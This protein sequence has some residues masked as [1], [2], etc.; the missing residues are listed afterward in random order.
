MQRTWF[1]KTLI[2]AATML[3]AISVR[4]GQ[5]E[6]RLVVHDK[7][8]TTVDAM[9]RREAIAQPVATSKGM[10][11]KTLGVDVTCWARNVML[12]GKP[13][14]ERYHD[15]KYVDRL[16]VARANLNP[17]DHTIWPGNHVFTIAKDGS[18]TANSPELMVDGNV[19][20]IKCYPFTVRA[21]RANPVE[22]APGAAR[23]AATL[24]ELTIREA[25]NNA[26]AGAKESKEK[27]LELLPEFE[28][29]SPLT[30]WL[31]GNRAE[32][33]YV[34]HPLGLMFHL[35]ADGAKP[36]AD[37]EKVLP[38][39]QQ[40]PFGVEIPLYSFPVQ[41]D[42]GSRLVTADVEQLRWQG[43]AETLE[44]RWF[45]RAKPYE[46]R[47]AEGA[48][49][50]RIDGDPRVRPFKNFRVDRPDQTK[51]TTRLLAVEFERRHFQPGETI[52]ARVQVLDSAKGLLR[53]ETDA[54]ITARLQAYEHAEWTALKA[55]VEA[56]GRLAIAVP[57]MTPGLYLLEV[58]AVPNASDKALAIRRWI[59]IA[60]SDTV[61]VGLFTRRGRTVF[62]RGEAFWLGFGATG[63]KHGLPAKT[64]LE[65]DLVDESGNAFP[66]LRD[67]SSSE[68]KDGETFVAKLD[69]D[70]SLKLAAGAYTA[71]ARIGSNA[72][73]PFAMEIVE[74][75]PET[76]F[77]NMLTGKY[78]PQ[79]EIYSRVLRNGQG[80][81]ALARSIAEMGHN[82]F[83]G[84]SYDLNRVVHGSRELEQVAR[85][86]AELGPWE[87]YYQPSGRDRFMEA[88]VRHNL[89]FYED[90]MTYNDTMLPRDPVILEALSRYAGLETASLR[91]SPAFKGVCLYDEI[92][93]V[94]DTGKP[95][96]AQ[97]LTA[98]EMTYRA[99]NPGLTSVDALRA[100]DRYTSRPFGQRK[101]EDLQK[102][103]TW[104]AHEDAEWGELSRSMASSVKAVM[105]ESKNFTLQR[106]W[107]GNGGNIAANG[108]A[109]DVFE[110]LD[111]AACV[112]YKDGGNGDRPVFA[113]MQ[114]D[115]LR[116]REDLP[117]WTQLHS[118][119]ASGLY[120]QHL[121][122]QAF[123]GLSQK[124]DGF[125]YFS[126][127]ASHLE[128]TYTDNR[129]VMRD[130][131]EKLCTPLGDFFLAAKRGYK[132]VA[133][134]YSR[135]ASYLEDKKPVKPAYACE[136]LWVACMRAGFPADFVFDADVRA[137]KLSEYDVVF[138]PGFYF[139]DE[140]PP[141]ILA[142]LRKVVN[143]G[144]V[145]AAERGS[146]LPI[147][148]LQRL[149]SDFDEYDDKMGGAFPRYIDF[150]S[151]MVWDQS[152][153]TT[154]L[155]RTF[156]G[157]H[158]EPAAEH[159]LLVGPDWLRSGKGEYMVLPNFADTGFSFLHKTM[160]QAPDTPRLRFPK[161]PPVCYDMLEMRRQKVENDGD[162]MTL[163]ADFRSC[164]GKIYAFMP[165]E[166]DRVELRVQP[167]V[168][169]GAPLAYA[170]QVLGKDGTAIDAAFP[171][172]ITLS[173]AKGAVL[174]R[175][176][177]AAAPAF[178]GVYAV[179][180]NSVAGT[181]GIAVR[182]LI[183]GTR[184]EGSVAVQSGKMPRA[185][186]D[187]AA[188]RISDLELLKKFM[189]GTEPVTIALDSNQDW[190][191]VEA[192]HLKKEIET[193]GREVK[194]VP[195]AK[196]VRLPVAWNEL[197]PIVDGT[198]LWR[199]NVVEPG[200][201][202]DGPLILIGKRNDNRLIDA[203]IQRD[204]LAESI[205]EH[206]PGP[207]CALL[208]CV[209]Q[210]FSNRYDT[211]TLLA[212]DTEGLRKGVEVLMTVERQMETHS[213]RSAVVTATPDEKAKLTSAKSTEAAPS[214][215]TGG[216]SNEDRVQTVNVDTASGRI[217][218][219]TFGYGK[220]LF[221][222][223][224]NGALLWKQFLPEHNVYS[225][226]WYDDGKRIVAATGMGNWVF[227]LD[228]KDGR[229][230]CKMLGSEWPN[231]HY[232]EGPANTEGQIVVNAAKRQI[233]V[234]G[235]TGILAIDFDGRKQWYFDRAEAI[236][237]YPELAEQT[238]A[239]Q[240]GN[241]VSVGNI[242]VSPNGE[243]VAYS[244]TRIVGTT[245][246]QNR[247]VD[248]WGHRPMLL[249]TASGKILVENTEDGGSNTSPGGW[250]VEYPAGANGPVFEN[251]QFSRVLQE[252]GKLGPAIA[253][254]TGTRLNDGSHLTC[255]PNAL[256]RIKGG[257][258]LWSVN[259]DGVWLPGFDCMNAA[260]TR[261]YRSSWD[262]R[263]RC[264]EVASGKT[265][266]EKPLNATARLT[267]LDGADA[268]GLLAAGKD[269]AL[270][271][272]DA[273]GKMLWRTRMREHNDI[274][275]RDYAAYVAAGVRRDT[276]VS[277][278]VFSTMVDRPGD[279]ANI[280][281][282]GIEQ[283]EN[284][285]FERDADWKLE[286]A[287]A[288]FVSPGHSAM[289][290]GLEEGRALVLKPGELVTQTLSRRVMPNTTYLLE[291]MY[292][293]EKPEAK[294]TAGAMIA[295]VK[296]AL[297][298]TK[299]DDASGWAFGRV[300][301]KTLDDSKS[302]TVGFEVE[303]G[304][305]WVDK[306]SL[307]PVRFP[308][309]N[310]LANTELQQ[311]EPTFVRDI[312]VQYN[313]I[314][315][316]LRDKL[317]NRNHVASF[318]QGDTNKARAFTQETAFLHNG[319]LD[320]VGAQWTYEP[321]SLGF[322]VTL[323]KP[324]YV[325][326][327]VLYLNN[328]TPE[329]TYRTIAVVANELD[330]GDEVGGKKQ[331]VNGM[332][333]LVSL[334]R[335]NT[336][337]FV[338][339]NFPK[340]IFTDSI[341]ILPGKHPGRKECITEIELYGPLGGETGKRVANAEPLDR[342]ML[343]GTASRVPAA[344]PEDL[345]G[346]YEPV[347]APRVQ[348]PV[349]N[350]GAAMFDGLFAYGDP[351]GE[352][353]SV[354]MLDSDPR[355]RPPPPEKGKRSPPPERIQEGP[356]WTLASVT[357]TTTPAHYAGR[358]F[359]GSADARLH[360]VAD[361]GTYL[362]AYKTGGRVYS[363]PLPNGDDVYFGSDD[364]KLYKI[365]VD[366]GALIWEYGTAGRVRGAPALADGIVCIA[367][368]DGF[369]HAVSADSG[370]QKWK[371]P[372]APLTRAT[373][374]VKGDAVFLGDEKGQLHAFD[375][376]SGAAKWTVKING[377]VSQCPVVTDDG[378]F[379]ASEQGEVAL[380]AYDG[381]LKWKRDLGARCSGQAIATQTQIIVPTEN[382][383]HVL[384]RADGKVDPRF[385]APE[386]IEKVISVGVYRSRVYLQTAEA[387]TDFKNPPRTYANYQGGVRVWAPVLKELKEGGAK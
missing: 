320:D 374:A 272:F 103:K 11:M 259:D 275:A 126:L 342:P 233:L 28:N 354:R 341:K 315:S 97:F 288:N 317:R 15:G 330:S 64:M 18:I 98:E 160:F 13:I 119:H 166:I 212:N 14:F 30:I 232:Y 321:D 52:T 368:G 333:R 264:V 347:Q 364:G 256:T 301:V 372:I 136:G 125:T 135:E 306:A 208:G 145:L 248:L 111:T 367:S 307:K 67:K 244:E 63:L 32:N 228:G 376:K 184:A 34:V 318:K 138:A 348:G 380:V 101:V 373:P 362:W 334:V 26:A 46:L 378:V 296:E 21:Y 38:G 369:L 105:P 294:L 88:A 183:S 35:S 151:E 71:I 283:L 62:Q 39:L 168:S 75:E 358:L 23:V 271:R 182:E 225:A 229:V 155:V 331:K 8:E 252:D 171:L 240:F 124:I 114:A 386:K 142:A 106:F 384:K 92:Y 235:L 370:L 234:R 313:R 335:G 187:T 84:M 236:A 131:A 199:G 312:R 336:R 102:Y 57:E 324:A 195:T 153:E 191:R 332:P 132:K 351:N 216:L 337:R 192:E 177:R 148:G 175:I 77:T 302:L 86:R 356:T 353:R 80:A 218:V 211:V 127:D 9:V 33:G 377:Y 172:E 76:H 381:A 239:A 281:R 82:S 181:V 149:E 196:L 56:D 36:V 19:V 110:P 157:K 174:Q 20:R 108:T 345:E 85:E 280:L 189:R 385:N 268:E 289:L 87:R 134:Y 242:A 143:G 73:Q 300:A 215:F 202:V 326:H 117:V 314:P 245:S 45:P 59:S 241:S 222:F 371:A 383:L 270:V 109:R 322:G 305:A 48:A 220:N 250:H 226:Q 147:D 323:M 140:T 382:G 201:F 219:G 262:G 190:C 293:V 357:P 227:L 61:G 217:L 197:A 95:M 343:M 338:V 133:I 79:G 40:T 310:L 122:R 206:F 291:F 284:G 193:P 205:S 194:I 24:P 298:A 387:T 164:P 200:L 278:A 247:L 221:C 116:V 3:G 213:A 319:R 44:T 273:T 180:V 2:L 55:L 339:V 5:V 96:S 165:Q 115:V 68:I 100:L 230:L 159:S 128:P 12:D 254:E 150:E 43:E 269:G 210:A 118:F 198:R 1:Y 292:R 130:I 144:K 285:D 279:Y 178:S 137:G 74:P 379:F 99:K 120:G 290:P 327:V 104:P 286:S 223:D 309:S 276:D 83:Q 107:G 204:V 90:I 66:L 185:R 257:A 10:E 267:V 60:T 6:L 328:A 91:H 295:G 25:T 238:L 27:A 203:L 129:D 173:D 58:L 156:L 350:A 53:L 340:P 123:F 316:T 37:A 303:G 274:P 4:A 188:V 7:P 163:E 22:S 366:S 141:D 16:P 186:L 207:E 255:A 65:V 311:I 94:A 214:S 355:T 329:N 352:V 266:W 72:S 17:G 243:Q 179:P 162:W 209:H 121:L 78:N 152:E 361:S 287:L 170:V 304:T 49:S 297:T 69:G 169:A 258:E 89:R 93:S 365:D 251:G 299:F 360:A 363:S 308:S 344:L 277:G 231:F 224:R 282:F 54:R 261:F 113:P 70:Q 112:M 325:S 31:P 246:V 346:S 265:L 375:I 139:E 260:Q 81:E 50:V 167:E 47:T 146:K 253:P 42:A 154:K 29:F 41:G 349:F 176:Y 51:A 359:V 237:S 263:V 249:D 158:I 161:R